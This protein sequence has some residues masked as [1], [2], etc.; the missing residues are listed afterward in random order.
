MRVLGGFG[1]RFMVGI[2]RFLEG[3][4]CVLGARWGGLWVVELEMYIWLSIDVFYMLRSGAFLYV[5]NGSDHCLALMISTTI[6]SV[7]TS[8]L[9]KYQQQNPRMTLTSRFQTRTSN[10]KPINILLLRQLLAILITHTTS[11][12]NPRFFRRLL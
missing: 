3:G 9:S 10:Q 1:I 4:L 6:L 7:S 8:H 5:T 11:I 12:N 2:R